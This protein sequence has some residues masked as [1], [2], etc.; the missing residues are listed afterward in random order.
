MSSVGQRASWLV[1]TA[2]RRTACPFC[3]AA[4]TA[5]GSS[6]HP[7]GNPRI[8]L[9]CQAHTPPDRHPVPPAHPAFPSRYGGSRPRGNGGRHIRPAV[10]KALQGGVLVLRV[11]RVGAV[12]CC[13]VL[14]CAAGA[15][16]ERW[17]EDLQ[18][19]GAGPV[20]GQRRRA[21]V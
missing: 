16:G 20:G 18:G 15:E 2:Q 7:L 8:S 3:L 17:E 6:N 9:C 21:G 14:C 19:S 10:R 5:S 4:A 1:G 12:L 11:L 13:A